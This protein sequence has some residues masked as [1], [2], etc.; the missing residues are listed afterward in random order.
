MGAKDRQAAFTG[1]VEDVA[2]AAIFYADEVVRCHGEAPDK[3]NVGEVR[4]HVHALMRELRFVDGQLE[5]LE[6]ALTGSGDGDAGC[7][8]LAAA[9]QRA[10][11]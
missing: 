8:V 11:V 10:T 3:E 6:T 4:R 9:S 1:A 2:D 5:E 7:S